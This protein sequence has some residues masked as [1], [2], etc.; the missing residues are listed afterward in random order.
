[1][2]L[3]RLVRVRL[4]GLCVEVGRSTPRIG[5]GAGSVGSVGNWRVQVYL[6]KRGKPGRGSDDGGEEA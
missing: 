4:L 2:T 5:H 1:M 3:R 6:S